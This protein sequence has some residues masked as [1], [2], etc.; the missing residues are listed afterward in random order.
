MDE[1]GPVSKALES[2]ALVLVGAVADVAGV[3]VLLTNESLLRWV[4]DRPALLVLVAA[5]LFL[6]VVAVVNRWLRVV[7]QVRMRDRQLDE[8]ELRFRSRVEELRELHERK[9][10][11]LERSPSPQDQARFDEFWSDFGFG[12]RL[13]NWF[14]NDYLVDRVRSGQMRALFSQVDKWNNDLTNYHDQDLARRF[15]QLR[16]AVQRVSNA[17]VSNYFQLDR[18]GSLA[19]DHTPFG[20]PPEWEWKAPERWQEAI[21]ELSAAHTDVMAAYTKFV[22]LAHAKKLTEK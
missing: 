6:A 3:L 12:T 10:A 13:Y 7:A 15:S 14:K 4:R 22:N 1:Q 16:E 21:D 2:S 17:A 19:D 5:S 9:I 11:E 18:S 20:V 8:Q